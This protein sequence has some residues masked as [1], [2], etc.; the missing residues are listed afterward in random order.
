M[1]SPVRSLY[2]PVLT[3]LGGRPPGNKSRLFHTLPPPITHRHTHTHTHTHIAKHIL[4]TLPL[5]GQQKIG[6]ERKEGECKGRRMEKAKGKWAA[7]G[8]ES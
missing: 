8:G 1:C 6:G 2:P 7:L 4:N 3:P 5:S